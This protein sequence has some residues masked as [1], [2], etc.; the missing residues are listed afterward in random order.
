MR[1]I[2]KDYIEECLTEQWRKSAQTAI[3][4]VNAAKNDEERKK[5]LNKQSQVWRDYFNLLPGHLKKKC[6]YCEAEEIRSDM[7]V[8]H[9]RPK[10]KVEGEKEHLGYW[11]LAFD[12][13]NYRCA[14]TYCN[15]RR[16][17]DE[18]EGG[19]AC[20]FPL[21]DPAKRAFLPEDD[22]KQERPDLLD[23]FDPDDERLLWFDSDGKPEPAPKI[24]I[25][26][27]RKVNNSIRVF[28]LNETKIVRLRN[29][30]RI[31]VENEVK[32]LTKAEAVDDDETLLEA[33]STLKKMVR[34]TE[35]HSRAA[36]V[37]LRAH[38]HL[39]AVKEILQ[40]D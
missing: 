39:P 21:V 10:N 30:I 28:H 19:K 17:F 13:K 3:E 11:W 27:Q 38:R 2:C 29:C 15:S 40:L 14:C 34:D 20:C 16:N 12:W 31:K 7:P 23:T 36:I 33:K 24:D 4:K 9:F 8:D 25:E 18:T 22:I 6:W 32:K 1:W 35:M 37:Y 5:I 26:K